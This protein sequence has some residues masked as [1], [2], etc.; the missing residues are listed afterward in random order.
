[1]DEIQ[2]FPLNHCFSRSQIETQFFVL[3]LKEECEVWKQT[4][5]VEEFL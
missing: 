1:M 4:L 5:F 3:A 2:W